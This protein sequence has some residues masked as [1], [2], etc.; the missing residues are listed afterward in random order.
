MN[1][2][3]SL[4]I[5]LSFFVI[6]SA[7][8]VMTPELLWKLGRVSPEAMS[9]DGKSIIYG[10]TNYSIEENKGERN[11]F[12]ISVNGGV[13][14]QLTKM[15]GGES[16]V[17]TLPNGKMGYIYKGQIYMCDWDGAN[18][19][20]LTKDAGGYSNVRISP[21][22]KYLLFSRDVKTRE[23]TADKYPDLPKSSAI[24]INDLQY[25]H[26]DTWED[27]FRSHVFYAPIT[28]NTI[29][30]AIDIMQGE[31][32]DCPQMPFGG[33]EDIIWGPDSKSIIYI[34]KKK[35]GTEYFTSTNTDIY[36]YNLETAKT[37][38][39]TEGMMGYDTQPT[40]SPDGKMLA[41]LSMEKDG[42]EADKNRLFI[43]D[44]VR[45]RKGD[46]SKNY[47][48]TIDQIRWS[49]DG[50]K[51]YFIAPTQSSYQLYAL[52]VMK[53][54]ETEAAL[55]N[56]REIS[57]GQFDITSIIGEDNENIYVSKMDMNHATEL[58]LLNIKNGQLKQITQTNTAIYDTLKLSTVEQYWVPTFDGTQMLVN[59]ILPPD[60]DKTKKY[61]MLL[62]CQ[63]GPQ[64]SLSQFYSFRWNFQL[65]AANGYVVIAPCR[66]G[67]PG[68]GTQWNELISGDWGGRPIK[69]YLYATDWAKKL[70]FVDAEKCAAVG[71]SYG[72]YSV[73]ML[74]GVG[75]GRYQSF[76]AHDG[77]FNTESFIGT[78]EEKWFANWDMGGAYWQKSQNESYSSF[79]PMTYVN[80]W[81]TPIMI[82]Q[83]GKDY[84]TTEDQAFQA[85]TAAQLKGIKS[86]LLYL[87]DEN[88][89]V[90]SA[91]NALVWQREFFSWLKETL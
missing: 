39:L 67:M 29:G 16:N 20:Q 25:R 76:I 43:Y 65:M 6:S 77:L 42:Y 69:D 61:P 81:K 71:A 72:G 18:T 91:Q 9:P 73:Y 46:L 47:D 55:S 78:T 79:N 83:G 49:N 26:W 44:F 41:W 19:T 35:S 68:F 88:H 5:C 90:L 75:E 40:L 14:M 15:I 84:R 51:I 38:N 22:G 82:I 53:A 13:S 87:P 23:T 80:K 64:S 4:F 85:F 36:L 33:A 31:D 66:R 27:E 32:Y 34:C 3:V 89:W 50:K 74:A 17:M 54:I 10:V 2:I 63:G 28:M 59:V 60:F 1:K 52:D 24:L 21:D 57:A 37:I 8:Q 58:F 11:L 48:E 30:A 12:S 7:Q 62:Y 45:N 70:P 56:I 86:K